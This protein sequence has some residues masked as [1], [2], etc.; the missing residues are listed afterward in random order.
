MNFRGVEEKETGMPRRS[1]SS[2]VRSFVAVAASVGFIALSGPAWSAAYAPGQQLSQQTITEFTANPSQL[3]SQFP[4][5]GGQMISRLR[6]LLASDPATLAPILSL[7]PNANSEQ[8]SALGSALAQAARLYQRADQ[9]F[10]AQIQQ[11]VANTQDQEL[12]VAYAAAA[13]DQ[14]IGAGGGAGSAGGPGGG[15]NPLASLGV[16]SSLQDIGG[17]AVD[18][19]PFSMTASA[20]SAAGFNTTNNNGNN[21]VSP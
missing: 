10:A 20:N 2:I 13:G 11:A 3:L 9:A 7:L 12:I 5:G 4:N 14:P 16:N 19:G 8:K 1:V 6:D 15:S 18:T 21:A 17:G